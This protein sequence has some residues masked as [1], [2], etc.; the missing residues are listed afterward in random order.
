MLNKTEE[1]IMKHWKGRV[2]SPP[3]V[4]IATITFNHKK[5]IEQALDSFL[6]QETS[7]PFEII[8]HDDLSTDGTIDI[9]KKYEIKYPHIIKP[10]YQ[11]ENQYSQGINMIPHT[12]VFPKAKGKYI[13]FCECDDYWTGVSKL[14][15]Q[16]NFLET[17]PEYSVCYHNSTI[18]DEQNRLVS[19]NKHPSPRDYSIEEMLLG[20]TFILT[21]TIMFRK[22]SEEA[23]KHH[24]K[25][26]KDVFNGDMAIMH[27]LG[28]MGK[29]KYLN[30]IDNAAYRVHSDGIWSSLN[31]VNKIKNL[32]HGKK[33]L[34][35]NL[36]LYPDIQVKM[37]EIID[38]DFSVTLSRILYAGD[39][40]G[41]K[42][43]IK[44]ILKD[45]E[46][47]LSIIFFKHIKYMFARVFARI[48]HSI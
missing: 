14:E 19:K 48:T 42:N 29:A 27:Q 22:F 38:K 6:L 26:Y 15:Q 40:Q 2:D 5:F 33:V 31:E 47:S 4:T 16:F 20:E 1:E 11:K 28:F 21:N 25:V 35:K 7:F 37:K 3:M 45:K 8:V 17:H 24:T 10:I 30:D 18:V 23:I 39:F 32:Y 12:F 36:N 41:Y 9:I 34:E 43:I 46:L 44:M 13:A